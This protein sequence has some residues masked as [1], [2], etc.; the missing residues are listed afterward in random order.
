MIY[1]YWFGGGCVNLAWR[2]PLNAVEAPVDISKP[3]ILIVMPVSEQR[4]GAELALLQLIRARTPFRWHVAFLEDGPMIAQVREAGVEASLVEAG[5][6]RQPH[7]ALGCV[8]RLARLG[9]R[10]NAQAM[11]GWMAKA[12]LYSGPAARLA[13]VPAIWFQHGLPSAKSM[14]D[15]LANRIPAAGVLACSQF[16]ADAQQRA[17]PKL[18]I[19]VVHPAADLEKFSQGNLP[20]S[21]ECKRQLKLPATGPII[22]IFGRLQRWKGMHVFLDALPAVFARYPQA[23]A[24]IVGGGWHL[25]AEYESKLHRQADV[26]RIADR[27]IF[28]GHQQN[29]CD[30]M[31]ACDIIVHASDHEPFGIVVLEAMALGKPIVAGAAGGPREVITRGVDGLLV[32]YGDAGALSQ[33]ILGYMDDPAMAAQTG[34]AARQRA[35]DFSLDRFAARLCDGLT[36]L[37]HPRPI[38]AEVGCASAT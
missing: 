29:V 23:A 37:M 9:K 31:Q 3:P 32:P 26:L 18:R 35:Q 13:G 12:H 2:Q 30:W 28:A 38:P 22:G 20:N 10:I 34:E 15:R 14:I 27:V 24:L 16:V 17:T 7:R 33:A 5:R 19:E 4:G 36:N 25:E 8:A 1:P 11:L 6:M 21:S